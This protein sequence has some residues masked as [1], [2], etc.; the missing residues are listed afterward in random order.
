MTLTWLEP[1]SSPT[2]EPFRFRKGKEI[3]VAPT[4][5]SSGTPASTTRLG[6]A[7]MYKN[8]DWLFASPESYRLDSS[9]HATSV[10]KE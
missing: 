1:M 2:V 3:I 6:I 7:Y 10:P 5:S 9:N 4:F 8:A